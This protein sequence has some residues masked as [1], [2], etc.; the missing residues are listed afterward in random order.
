M[1]LFSKGE[2]LFRNTIRKGEVDRDLTEEV[3]SYVELLMEKNMKEGM[4][5]EDARRYWKW[6]G[7]SR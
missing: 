4:S 2:S 3:S 7:W 6:A 1:K 5:Q